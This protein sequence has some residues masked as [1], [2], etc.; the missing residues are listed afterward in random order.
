L[1]LEDSVQVLNDFFLALHGRPPGNGGN[2]RRYMTD[3]MLAGP[4]GQIGWR[5]LSVCLG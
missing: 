5:A 2:L 4:R 3:K 1:F